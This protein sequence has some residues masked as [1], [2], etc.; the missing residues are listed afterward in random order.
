MKL[1]PTLWRTCRVI[2][3]ETRLQ[4]LWEIFKN[5]ELC[6]AELADLAGTTH[7]NASTQLRSLNARGL[8]IPTR[9]QQKLFY[10]PEAN[11]DVAHAEELLQALR[12]CYQQSVPFKQIIRQSTA[13]T[14]SRRI[15]IARE[16]SGAQKTFTNL[17]DSTGMKPPSL[18]RHL[19]KLKARGF[20]EQGDKL[21]KLRSPRHDFGRT[22]LRIARS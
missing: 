3:N 17:L 12:R 4:L 5:N 7:H 10:R 22:L 20:I 19:E 14:H 21:Y 9:K 8:L 16:L 13:F 11:E 18:S 2:A 6:V 1:R 15:E